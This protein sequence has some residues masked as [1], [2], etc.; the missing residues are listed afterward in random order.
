M[1][2][3]L[4]MMECALVSESAKIKIAKVKIFL[5]DVELSC[6]CESFTKCKACETH[7]IKKSTILSFT[8]FRAQKKFSQKQIQHEIVQTKNRLIQS[9]LFYFAQVDSMES[10]KNPGSVIIFISVRTGFLMRFGGGN[11]YGYIGKASLG[12]NRNLLLGYIGYN[13]NGISFLDE[14]AFGLPLILG[15]SFFTDVP[16]CFVNQS[17]IKL[18][19]ATKTGVHINPDL[20]LGFDSDVNFCFNKNSSRIF[21]VDA[22][23][24]PYISQTNYLSEKLTLSSEL[25]FYSYFSNQYERFKNYENHFEGALSVSYNINPKLTIAGLLSGGSILPLQTGE[26]NFSA[27]SK[28][29]LQGNGGALCDELSLANRGMRSGYSSSELNPS[30]Y[31]LGTLEFRWNALRFV[32]PP[33]FPCQL[34]PYLFTDVACAWYGK[35]RALHFWMR[36]G[37]DFK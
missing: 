4:W 15:A 30:S 7:S 16:S 5:D 29:N 23:F 33:F 20:K 12:G 35:I 26:E 13:K 8:K 32:I 2:L 6:E 1:F 14:N 10:K 22:I 19:L 27:F 9:K 37:S 31:I 18:E 17:G 34:V 21:F 36:M 11:A 28:I 3:F 24:S 25:R